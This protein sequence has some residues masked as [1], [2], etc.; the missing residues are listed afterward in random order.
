VRRG[1]AAAAFDTRASALSP[2]GP[3]TQGFRAATIPGRPPPWRRAGRAV[4]PSGALTM[5]LVEPPE[6][7][8]VGPG[9]L[10]HV[11]P[12]TP[13][14]T[15]DHGAEDLLVDAYGSP[16]ESEHAEVLPDAV[17]PT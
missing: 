15:V 1:R 6:R 12:G 5:Y 13:L 17:G 11:A 8:D 16:L 3:R 9:G 14:Q 7:H 2:G 4:V 10:I